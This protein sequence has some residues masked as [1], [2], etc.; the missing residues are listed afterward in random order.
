MAILTQQNSSGVN[1]WLL[2]VWKKSFKFDL[3]E[4]GST[5][6]WECLKE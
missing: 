3:G 5:Y 1:I 4:K 6:V 2:F